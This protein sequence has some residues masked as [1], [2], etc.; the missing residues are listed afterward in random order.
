MLSSVF[1]PAGASRAQPG[2]TPGRWL[3]GEVGSPGSTATLALTANAITCYPWD[4]GRTT[5]FSR[6][7]I[8]V[9]IAGGAGTKARL[10]FFYCG[11]D[12]LPSTLFFDAGEVAVDSTG[13]KEITI[14]Q[15]IRVGSYWGAIATD[16]T[17]TVRAHTTFNNGGAAVQ[18]IGVATPGT[19]D[20]LVSRAHT[21]GALSG[22]SPFGTPTYNANTIPLVM[23]KV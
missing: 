10:G 23:L 16:G 11:T 20:Q 14:S 9:T 19:L 18:R 7:A 13:V 6:I 1:L 22:A 21:Y 17:P 3:A 4:I 5:L 2:Y 8:D 15:L 12:G